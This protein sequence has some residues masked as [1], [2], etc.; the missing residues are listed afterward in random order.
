MIDRCSR[1]LATF[2]WSEKSK[3]SLA[4][5]A[6]IIQLETGRLFFPCLGQLYRGGNHNP[7]VVGVPSK[8]CEIGART[9]VLASY[10][11]PIPV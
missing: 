3:N 8:L 11:V 1:C 10:H 4:G 5:T 9:A 7:A 6:V 2:P